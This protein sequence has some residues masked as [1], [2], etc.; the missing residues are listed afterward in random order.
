MDEKSR[1]Y[2]ALFA[3]QH[4]MQMYETEVNL[5]M[6]YAWYK[7]GTELLNDLKET[8]VPEHMMA[9]WYIG[10][11]GMAVKGAGITLC[12]DPVLNDLCSP[13]GTSRRNYEPPFSGEEWTGLD[14]VI[15]SHNHADHINLKT[16]LPLQQANP[17][18]QFIVPAPEKEVLTDGGIRPEAV[19]GAK[20][21]E[22]IFLKNG[23]SVHPVA[24]AHETYVTD[25]NGDQKNLGYVLEADGITMYHAGDTMVTDRL[26]R[27]L[28]PFSRIDL[29]CIPVNGVDTE[30]HGRGIIGN[31]DCRDAAYFAWRIGADLTVPMHYDMVVGNGEDPLIFARYMQEMYTGKKYRIMQLG[32]MGLVRARLL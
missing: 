24:A 30:R 18:L 5:N 1:L 2:A 7:K 3:F 25:E 17:S 4:G 16:L 28:E 20:A 21:G 26:I 11:M 22:V 14:Y 23:V 6:K 32:E 13:D 31:M 10:Q 12:F 8:V 29:A 27:D 19:I 9:F 15:C